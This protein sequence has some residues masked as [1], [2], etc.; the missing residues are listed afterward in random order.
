MIFLF[1]SSISSPQILLSVSF[2]DE[3]LLESGTKENGIVSLESGTTGGSFVLTM[4][5]GGADMV[6]GAEA[7]EEE[8]EEEDE[9]EEEK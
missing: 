2:F 7:A 8:E 3:T 9:D 6:I 5:G 1:S 4:T